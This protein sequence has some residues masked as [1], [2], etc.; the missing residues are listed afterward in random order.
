MDQIPNA[1]HVAMYDGTWHAMQAGAVDDITRSIASD[2]TNVY[3]GSDSVDIAGIAQAD[4]VAKWNGSAWSALGANT[5]RTDG[6]LPGLD[7]HQ[8]AGHERIERVRD[9]LVPECQRRPDGRRGRRVHNGF[10]WA[11]MGSDGAGNGPLPGPGNAVAMFGGQVV[12][13]GNFTTAGGDGRASYIAR[14]PGAAHPL[15]AVIR[16]GE[17]RLRPV[18]RLHGLVRRQLQHRRRADRRLPLELQRRLAGQHHADGRPSPDQA[19][20]AHGHPD[21]HRRPRAH[22]ADQRGLL[23]RRS[24]PAGA[25]HLLAH[26]RVRRRTGLV[27]RERLQRRRRDDRVL[28]LAVGRRRRPTPAR[29]SRSTRSPAPAPTRSPCSCAT[30]TP[31]PAGRIHNV[32]R[33]QARGA[34][35]QPRDADQRGVQRRLEGHRPCG[36]KASVGTTFKFTLAAPAKVKVAFSRQR[37]RASR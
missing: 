23:H 33:A 14:Y 15:T 32:D 10:S 31:S 11:P 36:A 17:R 25:V 5:A 34:E 1:D 16:L 3:I 35:G 19:G 28:R 2:G 24:V 4:H 6:W 12:V 13:G 22:R 7:L 9:R 30:T 29:P 8:R 21:R 37:Q 27:R 26:H 18:R 20:K